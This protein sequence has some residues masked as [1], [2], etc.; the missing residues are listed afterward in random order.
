M[1]I[2]LRATVQP[3]GTWMGLEH[4]GQK[5]SLPNQNSVALAMSNSARTVAILGATGSIGRSTAE[6]V[7]AAP[8]RLKIVGL[9]ANR[10][11]DELCKL[12]WQVQP[13]WVVATDEEAAR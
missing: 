13:R 8:E 1:T 11:L 5:N 3:A 7:Q 10:H 6:V 2:I 4:A 9:T 12:A